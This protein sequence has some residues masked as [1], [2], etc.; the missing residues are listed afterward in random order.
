[1]AASLEQEAVS[2]KP[3]PSLWPYMPRLGSQPHC[4][5]HPTR[6]TQ[7]VQGPWL[8]PRLSCQQPGRAPPAPAPTS[9]ATEKCPSSSPTGSS[10]QLKLN[11]LSCAGPW[12]GG[13]MAATPQAPRAAPAALSS[14]AKC[15]REAGGISRGGAVGAPLPQLP[16]CDP[17]LVVA[18][19]A[20]TLGRPCAGQH[21]PGDSGTATHVP[22]RSPEPGRSH[23]M[24]AFH[25]ADLQRSAWL[26]G[27]GGV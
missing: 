23:R 12:A 17:A 16:R 10:N 2:W 13:L 4:P 5:P 11:P 9:G 20:G 26:G 24:R 1:M 15:R 8:M 3:N 18:L 19:Y 7:A 22:P 25:T 14:A 27:G 6:G 21:G